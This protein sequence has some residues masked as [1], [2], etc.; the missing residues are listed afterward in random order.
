MEKEII[1]R[2]KSF[3]KMKDEEPFE[4]D[5]YTECKYIE[6]EDVIELVYWEN[7]MMGQKSKVV[8]SVADEA[9]C[10]KRSGEVETKMTFEVGKR[11]TSIYKTPYGDF[12]IELL[13]DNLEI[14][15]ARDHGC[16]NVE[17][18][19]SLSG[20]PEIKNTLNVSY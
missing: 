11:E 10:M 8:L 15:V 19:V 9:L 16:I 7:E 6:K 5:L 17:Y 14:D 4:M 13:T 1:L 3:Q 12:K 20:S 18:T 2:V